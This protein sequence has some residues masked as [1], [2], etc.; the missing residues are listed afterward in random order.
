MRQLYIT[1]PCFLPLVCHLPRHHHLPAPLG[2][3]LVGAL[4][5]CCSGLSF[6]P[7]ISHLSLKV[8]LH[9]ISPTM[10]GSRSDTFIARTPPDLF[11]TLCFGRSCCRFFM[12]AMMPI[13][14]VRLEGGI[15]RQVKD[16]GHPRDRPLNA[17]HMAYWAH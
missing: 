7:Q 14:K 5:S 13:Y 15:N 11:F 6:C 4:L 2:V 16:L 1:P 12:I 9:F 8:R 10:I 3:S 17:R